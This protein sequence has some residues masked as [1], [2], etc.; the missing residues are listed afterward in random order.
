MK[1]C[2][3]ELHSTGKVLIQLPSVD[4]SILVA[5]THGGVAE[6]LVAASPG[7][8]FQL[9]N[10]QGVEWPALWLITKPLYAY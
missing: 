7:F 9:Y 2:S 6:M 3:D 10:R 5:T 1:T 4:C 8:L